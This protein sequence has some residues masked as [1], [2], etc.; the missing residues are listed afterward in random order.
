MSI[1]FR[2]LH[3][4][5]VNWWCRVVVFLMSKMAAAR[6]ALYGV[7]NFYRAVKVLCIQLV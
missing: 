3:Q 1:L 2:G 4:V 7:L 6:Q 5:V